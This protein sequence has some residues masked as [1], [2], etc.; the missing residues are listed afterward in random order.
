MLYNPQIMER[1]EQNRQAQLSF[2][3]NFKVNGVR[4]ITNPSEYKPESYKVWIAAQMVA[5]KR[6]I[7]I[8]PNDK[9]A[10]L[11]PEK[12]LHDAIN[13]SVDELELFLETTANAMR[14]AKEVIFREIYAFSVN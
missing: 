5:G 12:T 9:K 13:L 1:Q 11:V 10:Y 8:K 14:D 6:E 7:I 4:V 2:F 3:E